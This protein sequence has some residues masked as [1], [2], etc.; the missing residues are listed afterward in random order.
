MIL[1]NLIMILYFIQIY[2]AQTQVF[3]PIYTNNKYPFV[4]PYQ[5]NNYYYVFTT[6]KGLKID[7]DN[8]NIEEF[9]HG[10]DYSNESI[11]CVDKSNNS[12]L[13]YSQNFYEINYNEY[14]FIREYNYS[15]YF[16]GST[17]IEYY[18][19]IYGIDLNEFF[20]I[21]KKILWKHLLY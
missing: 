13:Y 19:T 11:Y 8:G 21:E 14:K 15:G 6:K 16:F 2:H 4:L 17:T 10:L 7:K 3:R 20:F 12:Y 5:D 9:D 18:F 1:I